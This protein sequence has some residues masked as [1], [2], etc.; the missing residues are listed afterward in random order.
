MSYEPED[1][2]FSRNNNRRLF[3]LSI[4]EFAPEVLES[5]RDD[6][7]A[8]FDVS[9]IRRHLDNYSVALDD[10]GLS[11]LIEI[12]DDDV[13]TM[14]FLDK[15]EQWGE[16]WHLS[17]DWL[18]DVSFQTLCRWTNHP[19][20]LERLEWYS[21][22]FGY[23][24]PSDYRDHGINFQF[25]SW[26]PIGGEGR[27]EFAELAREAFRDSL[28][29]YLNNKKDRLTKSG[30]VK[31]PREKNEEHLKWLVL[32]Q[33]KGVSHFEIAKEQFP[34]EWKGLS[35]QVDFSTQ[36]DRIRK[37]ISSGAKAIGLMRRPRKKP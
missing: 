29:A 34:N 35:K 3:L 15:L 30:Y 36:I 21:N 27:N 26:N 24:E 9:A 16:Q 18:L 1:Q 5:L 32:F 20:Y 22:G 11:D 19:D 13:A 2:R 6:L 25:R 4:K 14:T 17:M 33:V 8:S 28:N 7:F 10:I 31:S 12:S 23:W 37:G